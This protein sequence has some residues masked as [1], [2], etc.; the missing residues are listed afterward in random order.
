MRRIMLALILGAVVSLPCAWADCG[1]S[2]WSCANCGY[3][4]CGWTLNFTA[5]IGSSNWTHTSCSAG[6]D[7]QD[8]CSADRLAKGLERLCPNR[9]NH[10]YPSVHPG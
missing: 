2:Q 4:S 10:L 5:P 1:S 8:G 7:C 6:S 3:S 9:E